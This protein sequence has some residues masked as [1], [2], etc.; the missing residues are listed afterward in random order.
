MV[1]NSLR[2]QMYTLFVYFFVFGMVGSSWV[3]RLPEVRSALHVSTAQLGLVLFAG[4]IGAMTGI[5]LA[6]RYVAKFGSRAGAL[7]GFNLVFLGYIGQATGVALESVAL[8]SLSAVI[9][10]LGYG[11][12][13]VAINVEGTDME[14]RLSRSL[15][16][17]LHGAYSIGTLA[18]AGIGTVAIAIGVPLPL[19]IYA[20]CAIVAVVA[21]TTIRLLPRE[22]GRASSTESSGASGK[23]PAV[24]RDP[25]IVFLGLALLCITLGEGAGLDWLALSMVDD[26]LTDPVRASI[27]FAVMMA[28]M[29]VVRFTGGFIIDRFGRVPVLRSFAVAGIIGLLLIILSHV[30]WLALVGAALWGVGV[31]LGFPVLLSAAA[32]GDTAGSSRRVSVV[33]SFGY[34]AFLSGPPILGLIGEAWGLLNMFY[35]LVALF[36][37]SLVF[38]GAAK[39][40][41]SVT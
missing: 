34:I 2:A 10:G 35:I 3:V 24:W 18:G 14:K 23:P 39:Q 19:Q 32:D 5:L 12:G 31:A 15:M 21:W 33:A 4:A 41:Q 11:L 29:T 20:L 6:G 13:D 37:A 27:A 16:P 1:K 25:R 7:L 30:Y 40:R 9:S 28:A 38:A 26:Y 36:A 22:T 8:V 17:P